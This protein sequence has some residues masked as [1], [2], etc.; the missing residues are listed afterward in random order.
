MSNI[1]KETKIILNPFVSSSSPVILRLS[2]AS[3]QVSWQTPAPARCPVSGGLTS[4]RPRHPVVAVSSEAISLCQYVLHTVTPAHPISSLT[5]S[6]E[7][8]DTANTPMC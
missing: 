7:S 4:P 2:V 6:L 1:F 5:A 3:L 8:A